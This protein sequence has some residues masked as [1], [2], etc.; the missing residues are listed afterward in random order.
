METGKIKWYDPGKGYGFIR[1]DGG[2]GD[3]FVHVTAVEQADLVR[4]HA[5]DR[6][7]FETEVGHSG[8]KAVNISL[9]G[10]PNGNS[11]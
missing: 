10:Y 11:T 4:L 6:I 9:V 8:T 1:P 7:S 2:G 3:I 5:E